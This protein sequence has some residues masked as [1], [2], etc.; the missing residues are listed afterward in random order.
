MGVK[1]LNIL[2]GIGGEPEINRVIGATG[3]GA[4]VVGAHAFLIWDVV[5]KGHPFDL[6]A[7]CVSFPAGLGIAVGSI[8]GAVALKDR[9]VATAIQTRDG[10]A[11]PAEPPP[12]AK[13]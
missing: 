9:N 2:Q 3:A 4:Y 6:T 13:E 5:V 8:A 7:Y 12:N 10:T 1:L 11:S